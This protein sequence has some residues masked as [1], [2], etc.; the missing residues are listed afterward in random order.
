MDSVELG[1]VAGNIIRLQTRHG[2]VSLMH[3]DRVDVRIGQRVAAGQVIGATGATGRITGAH[4][5]IEVKPPGAA[6]AVDP[7]PYFL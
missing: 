4:L 1:T 7:A 6:G 2:R 3:L 5:H